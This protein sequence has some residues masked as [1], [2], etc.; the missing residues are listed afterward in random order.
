MDSVLNSYYFITTTNEHDIYLV[1][2]I[3]IVF[4]GKQQTVR[5]SLKFD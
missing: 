1:L 3:S 4:I 5:K 2:F